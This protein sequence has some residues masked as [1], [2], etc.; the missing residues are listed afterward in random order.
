VASE[1]HH[2]GVL[3]FQRVFALG[4]GRDF[5]NELLSA[6]VSNVKILVALT[7]ELGYWTGKPI[8][9]RG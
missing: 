1:V 9:I 2:Y 5:Q 8:E 7:G 6:V 3:E 4:R